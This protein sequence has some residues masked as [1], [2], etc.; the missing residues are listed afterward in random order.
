MVL[1]S[2]FSKYVLFIVFSG[3][4]SFVFSQTERFSVEENVQ[5]EVEKAD[6][7]AMETPEY[8]SKLCDYI[9]VCIEDNKL[10]GLV[11]K[12]KFALVINEKLYS[13]TNPVAVAALLNKLGIV[14][15]NLADYNK[16]VQ[17][18]KRTLDLLSLA[19][20][21]SDF[22]SFASD[23]LTAAKVK[24]LNTLGMAYLEQKHF[25]KALATFRKALSEV[26]ENNLSDDNLSLAITNNIC[27]ALFEDTS[28]D[29]STMEKELLA[30]VGAYKEHFSPYS[31]LYLSARNNLASFYMAMDQ[32]DKALRLYEE[33]IKDFHDGNRMMNWQYVNAVWNYALTLYL[34][35]R[36]D[37][38]LVWHKKCL[39]VIKELASRDFLFLSELEREKYWRAHNHRLKHFLN[40][41]IL[42]YFDDE[43]KRYTAFAYDCEL[44]AKNLLLSSAV[45]KQN[46]IYRS[47]NRELR[48]M[49]QK[50]KTLRN[51]SRDEESYELERKL[52]N[53]LKKEGI[54]DEFSSDWQSIRQMLEPDEAAIEIINFPVEIR[55]GAPEIYYFALIVRA[56]TEYSELI[57]L[58]KEEWMHIILAESEETIGSLY[59]LIWESIVPYLTDI[60]TLY[61]APSGLFSTISFAVFKNPDGNYITGK[62]TIHNLLSTRDIAI[63]K[64]RKEIMSGKKDIVLFGGADFG[65]PAS[66]LEA[67]DNVDTDKESRSSLVRGTVDDLLKRRGQ[68]FDFL[69][70]SLAEVQT[71]EKITSAA[72]WKT[73]LFTDTKATET[74]LKSYSGNSPKVLHIS[75]HG[76][77]F[78]PPDKDSLPDVR[79]VQGNSFNKAVDPM[80]RSG[81]LLSGANNIWTGKTPADMSNDGV[82]TAYEIANLDFSNTELVVLSACDTGLGDID[83]SE[84][85]Y[86]LQRAFRLAGVRSMIISL[87]KVPDE[88]TTTLMTAFY[89]AWTS[90]LP[91]KQA[92]EKAQQDL[93]NRYP[94][95]PH[96]WGG[97]VLIE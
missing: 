2:T 21:P 59:N 39:D 84:G 56:D 90:G 12:I 8:L 3:C 79:Q 68:G 97:F 26:R 29:I 42:N 48:A 41:A 5:W 36:R 28:K 73:S 75:T 9:D 30:I 55:K 20:N 50:M 46:A 65:L 69:P 31:I 96:K 60:A 27:S 88:E 33:V 52:I 45:T 62:H 78:S 49:W 91:M 25:D 76:F 17:I 18:S 13:G 47:G 4:T 94:A 87:W 54:S 1:N 7:L 37:D 74:R 82:L 83:Y 14:Y 70:G 53:A 23:S 24:V 66:M 19:S 95:E 10:D 92:F 85:I 43:D 16:V 40:F 63:L 11:E 51:A 64:E 89:T 72:K 80:M 77:Y 22:D 57:I 61:V 58:G 71:I 93:R 67:G 81:L 44:F 38:A 6:S 15:L 86:G 32:Y 35:K 34:A